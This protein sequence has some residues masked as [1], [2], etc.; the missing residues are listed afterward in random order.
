V[1]TAK[2]R[3]VKVQSSAAVNN[4]CAVPPARHHSRNA[5]CAGGTADPAAARAPTKAQ[6]SGSA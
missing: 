2:L 4:I 3:K 5:P 1:P 6:A